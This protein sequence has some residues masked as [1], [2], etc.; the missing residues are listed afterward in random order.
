VLGWSL[1]DVDGTTC[2]PVKG[3]CWGGALEALLETRVMSGHKA[4][5]ATRR[6]RVQ[7]VDERIVLSQAES[8]KR[9]MRQCDE[10]RE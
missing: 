2:E 6:E 9:C 7:R 8:D 5:N 4:A 1:V 3:V 10:L